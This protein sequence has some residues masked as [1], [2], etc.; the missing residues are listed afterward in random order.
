MPLDTI[1]NILQEAID[2]N[3]QHMLHVVGDSTLSLILPLIKEAGS[4][5][6][7]RKKR[8]RFEH[9]I[10]AGLSDEQIQDIKELGIVLMPTPQYVGASPVASLL[11][12]QIPIGI[13]PDGLI[14]PFV[15]IMLISSLH[16]VPA[17]NI[18]REEAVIAYTLGN[19]FAEF[20][21]ME[22]GT[23]TKGKLADLA[24]LTH[25]IFTIPV[26]ELP[27]VRSVLT[28][29]DGKIVYRIQD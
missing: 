9:S 27:E 10:P 14:N 2:S 8:L 1:K 12:N 22:K 13:A 18:S 16:E 25:D 3:I 19:A 11:K 5:E 24:V 26:E 23:L 4:P 15:H 6:T 28:M 7:W 29:V 20:A 21:E 17:E